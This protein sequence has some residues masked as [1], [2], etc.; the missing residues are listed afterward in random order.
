MESINKQKLE[1]L[2]SDLDLSIIE[3]HCA[4][5]LEPENES[6]CRF[7]YNYVMSRFKASR[8][9]ENK[10]YAFI[11]ANM[12]LAP[13]SGLKTDLFYDWVF[14]GSKMCRKRGIAH[15]NE[16]IAK[17][18]IQNENDILSLHPVVSKT[19]YRKLKPDCEKCHG[20]I[21]GLI[22][23]ANDC[24]KKTYVE[25]ADGVKAL[26]LA[27]LRIDKTELAASLFSE[28][29]FLNN[30]L[31]RHDV[32]IEWLLKA[33]KIREVKLGVNNPDTAMTYNSLAEVYYEKGNHA[34]A[35]EWGLSALDVFGR[36]FGK[37]HPSTA[38]IYNTIALICAGQRAY[39]R[40]F[41][42]LLDA[43]KI[44]EKTLSENHPDIAKTKG[45]IA[46]V[47]FM[48]GKND[49]ALEWYRKSLHDLENASDSEYLEIA[50]AYQNTAIVYD[51]V[52]DIQNAIEHSQKALKN[53]FEINGDYH[54]KVAE[55]YSFVAAISENNGK[56]KTAAN[57]YHRALDVYEKNPDYHADALTIRKNIALACEL[58]SEHEQE[59]ESEI[60]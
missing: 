51:R 20:M 10:D 30:S 55:I 16:L 56:F 35:L 48:L 27:C 39:S 36:V 15:L 22:A 18:W 8:I 47:W 9:S 24:K 4:K 42:M 14:N 60:D 28:F 38:L 21:S 1:P 23:Y 52:G 3:K 43:L 58:S 26:E 17:G 59:N 29:A 49:T 45:N 11:M 2:R 7:A 37:E 44:Q 32:A 50:K 46:S 13:Y 41:E 34:K 40:S 57:W 5:P 31:A 6:R 53:Y 19:A 25:Q 33:K 12:S 54:P